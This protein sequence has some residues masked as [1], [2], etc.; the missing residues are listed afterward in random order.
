MS[1]S[2]GENSGN[3]PSSSICEVYVRTPAYAVDEEV[4]ITAVEEPAVIR[5]AKLKG[6]CSIKKEAIVAE[7][8]VLSLF[9]DV[10]NVDNND[11]IFLLVLFIFVTPDIFEIVEILD[12]VGLMELE[13]LVILVEI[14]DIVGLM[15]LEVLVI[16]VEVKELEVLVV[17]ELIMPIPIADENG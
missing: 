4:T 11:D 7:E 10:D 16:L 13:V 17:D 9:D 8:T 12:I 2:A 6:K 5:S 1:L 14:L 15:K 3:E